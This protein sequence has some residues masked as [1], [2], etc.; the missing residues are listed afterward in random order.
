MKIIRDI[1]AKALIMFVRLYQVTLRPIMGGHCRFQPTCSDYTIQALLKHGPVK[2][3]IKGVWRIL[4]CN[5][6][7]GSGY[8]P[9]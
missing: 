9:P 2:G 6:I 1:L 4:R 8:D 7:G 3:F 5:P